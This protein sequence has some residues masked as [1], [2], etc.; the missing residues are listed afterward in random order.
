M[1]I[2]LTGCAGHLAQALLPRLCEHPDIESV[3]GVDLKVT[4]FCHPKFV[5]CQADYGS[6][7]ARF[8]MAGCDALVH[9]GFTVLRGRMKADAMW[10]NNVASS[11]VLFKAA[12]QARIR[13]IVH[14][15]SA[16]VYGSG[17]N[18]SEIDPLAPSPGF[19]YAR[20]KAELERWMQVHQP[21]A[22]RLRPH[23]ILGPHALPLLKFLLRQPC[24]MRLPEP[25]PLLQCVHEQDVV[26]AIIL[27]LF[28]EASGP[29]NLAAKEAFSF[30]D[31]V[32]SR[33]PVPIALPPLLARA[34]LNGVWHAL[35]AGGEPGWLEE[36]E[37]TFTLDCERARAELG[38]QAA[39]SVRQAVEDACLW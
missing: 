15:S 23:T 2:F 10:R 17:E 25:Q 30:R 27:S 35:G 1:K 29:F 16:A 21:H 12:D 5:F 38:W 32:R 7:K 14:V 24:Y 3:S 20:H 13:R 34:V 11:Q 9:L 39:F 31:L 18:L 36:A 4:D 8:L 22:V 28:S 26:S 6:Q 37:R 19:L 33:H